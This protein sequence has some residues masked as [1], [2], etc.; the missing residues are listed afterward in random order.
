[1]ME[2]YD[3]DEIE[4]AEYDVNVDALDKELEDFRLWYSAQYYLYQDYNKYREKVFNEELVRRQRRI[5]ELE[6]KT[7]VYYYKTMMAI[8]N[9]DFLQE[10][11]E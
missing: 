10:M 9:P 5:K 7:E 6:F 11:W 2:E 4:G 8:M 1:M 3:Q